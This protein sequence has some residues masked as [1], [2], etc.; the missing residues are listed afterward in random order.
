MKEQ[1]SGPPSLDAARF[2]AGQTVVVGGGPFRGVNAVVVRRD[3]QG[4][5][6]GEVGAGTYVRIRENV[7][8]PYPDESL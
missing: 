5:I 6:L 1:T 4:V 3:A 2:A 7:V 8:R